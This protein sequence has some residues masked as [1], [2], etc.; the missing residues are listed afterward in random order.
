MEEASIMNNL[1]YFGYS[2]YSTMKYMN[3]VVTEYF[4]NSIT[5]FKLPKMQKEPSL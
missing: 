4:S 1:L 5:P 2:L 3:E